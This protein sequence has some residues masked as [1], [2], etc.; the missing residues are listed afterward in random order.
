MF[1]S[2]VVLSRKGPLGRIWVAAHFDKR[3]SKQQVFATDIS[4]SVAS[5]LNPTVPLALRLSGQL[6][7]G[8]VRIYSRKVKYLVTDCTEA[9]WKMRL[10]FRGGNVDM[11]EGSGGAAGGGISGGP[12]GVLAGIDDLRHFGHFEGID[13]EEGVAGTIGVSGDAG[14]LAFTAKGVEDYTLRSLSSSSPSPLALRKSAGDI[15][16]GIKEVRSVIGE[17]D[18][19]GSI[20]GSYRGSLGGHLSELEYVRGGGVSPL[21]NTS[22]VIPSRHPSLLGPPTSRQ[23]ARGS[24]S[25]YLARYGGLEPAEGE[26]P[27]FEEGA[28]D[29]GGAGDYSLSFNAPPPPTE[30]EQ[31][32]PPAD[33]EQGGR[34]PPQALHIEEGAVV[35]GRTGRGLALGKRVKVDEHIELSERIIKQRLENSQP[36]LRS[37]TLTPPSMP[38]G[39]AKIEDRLGR[40]HLYAGLCPELQYTINVAT[41]LYPFPFPSLYPLPQQPQPRPPSPSIEY[42]RREEKEGEGF[43]MMGMGRTSSA[44]PTP[45]ESLGGPPPAYEDVS[46]GMDTSFPPLPAYEYP[47]QPQA[48]AYL[49]SRDEVRQVLATPYTVL[50]AAKSGAVEMSE[51]TRGVLGMVEREASK[52]GGSVSFFS[53]SSSCSRRTASTLFLELLQLATWGRVR[54]AQDDAYADI[55][56]AIDDVVAARS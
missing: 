12:G 34:F 27:A 46:F 41:N 36:I 8:I 50:G 51:R 23:G 56:V 30:E 18:E 33:Y 3:L 54:M 31:P 15:R 25:S 11:L 19:E 13:W 42:A 35:V 4:A 22:G 5:V 10:A 7:L 55:E 39:G 28:F 38:F 20:G 6:M 49:P 21:Y 47:E 43:G 52:G 53:L 16:R 48:S 29:F 26:L 44:Y 2:Q 1:Y 32:P 37:I 9:M 40:A 17:G 24:T 45:R 14:G